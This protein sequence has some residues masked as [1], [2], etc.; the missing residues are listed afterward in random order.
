MI[1]KNVNDENR[2]RSTLKIGILTLSCMT[3]ISMH[4]TISII[5]SVLQI[6][7]DPSGNYSID[8]CLGSKLGLTIALWIV[9]TLPLTI[10]SM[11]GKRILYGE[12]PGL[13]LAM[14]VLVYFL[15]IVFT[16]LSMIIARFVNVFSITFGFCN[17]GVFAIDIVSIGTVFCFFTPIVSSIISL[18]LYY[19]HSSSMKD[20]KPEIR[21]IPLLIQLL[22]LLLIVV[23]IIPITCFG[24]FF[25]R[26][27][28]LDLFPKE[29]I[30][31][32][33][34]PISSKITC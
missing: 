24:I 3:I 23:V 4:F 6:L 8:G 31:T 7:M 14:P 5:T 2:T 11:I 21:S 30:W 32:S 33:I 34:P 12:E 9:I 16:I 25:A 28:L 20:E 27:F 22:L 10:T 29:V 18:K 1:E 13:I 26:S 19:D 15:T 17:S